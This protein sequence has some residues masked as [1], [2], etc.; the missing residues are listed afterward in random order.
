MHGQDDSKVPVENALVFYNAL[1]KNK[2]PAELHVL[3]RGVHGFGLG[4]HAPETKIWKQLFINWLTTLPE[5]K[6]AHD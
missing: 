6:I 4:F 3:Q 2:I 5:E 1:T